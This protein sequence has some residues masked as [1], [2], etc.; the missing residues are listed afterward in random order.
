MTGRPTL[1]STSME[2]RAS[3]KAD[4]FLDTSYVIALSSPADRF[5][6]RAARFAD[7]IETLNTHMLTSRAVMIEIGNAL[8]KER[9]RQA[10]IMLLNSL[11]TDPKVEIILL[12]EELYRQSFE[13]FCQRTDKEWGL[14]DCISFAVMQQRGISEALTTDEHFEQAGFCALLREGSSWGIT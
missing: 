13:L 3:M 11:E 12:N 1:M 8:S 2:G 9:Y 6:D 14:I 10:A 5:H 4:L 7:Q